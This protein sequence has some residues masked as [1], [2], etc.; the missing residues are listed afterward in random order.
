MKKFEYMVFDIDTIEE[1]EDIFL[2]KMGDEGWELITIN[3]EPLNNR[4]S[5]L[6]KLYFKRTTEERRFL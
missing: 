4:S 2:N 6:V 1:P 5:V 3:N